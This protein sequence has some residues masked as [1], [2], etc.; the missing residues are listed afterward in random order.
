MTKTPVGAAIITAELV[1]GYHLFIPL[2][3]ATTIRYI[4]TGNFAMYENQTTRGWI[5]V[6]MDDLNTIQVKDLMVR[7]TV[8]IKA[9][10]PVQKAY[11]MAEVEP[12]E[13]YPVLQ[14]GRVVGVV[15]RGLLEPEPRGGVLV[16]AR[17]SKEFLTVDP[18]A[19]AKATLDEMTDR[20]IP[21]AVVVGPAGVVGLLSFEEVLGV[22][23]NFCSPL[24]ITRRPMT[25]TCEEPAS[26]PPGDTLK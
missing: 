5:P 26:G 4:V 12:Q 14:D 21:Q 24:D 11:T 18:E 15:D 13:Y 1:G 7:S 16:S 8:K 10:D 25:G 6:T 19:T 3:I 17:M 23:G 2:V 9:G 22:L 20:G